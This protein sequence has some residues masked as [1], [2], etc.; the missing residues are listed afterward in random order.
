MRSKPLLAALL[1]S[2]ALMSSAG[3]AP[4]PQITDAKG[5]QLP[6][7]NAGYDIVS[8]LFRTEG[9]TQRVGRKSVYT[10]TKLLV[11]VTYAGALPKD[12]HAAQVVSFDA[13][14][15]DGIYMERYSAGL[16]GFTGCDIE[17]FG[18]SV[19]ALGSSL[20]FTLP[21]KALGKKHLFKGATLT[22]LR[23]YT[24]LADPAFG[25]ESGEVL[26]QFGAGPVDSATT[27]A[28]YKIS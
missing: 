18:F 2:L 8:A 13:P 11:T 27:T 9:Q 14:G 3:A 1:A 5:D 28:A 16:W 15:C 23:T 6:V 7:G 17:E 12:A 10:P 24:A 21:F 25:Y 26:G 20:T 19:K 4:R 22:N